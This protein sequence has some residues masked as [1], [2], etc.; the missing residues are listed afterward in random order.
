VGQQHRP[1]LGP[2]GFTLIELAV[3]LLVLALAVA[4][5]APA[6]SRSTEAIRMRAEVGRFSALLRHAR[7][8]AIT[9]RQPQVLVVDPPEHRLTIL[10]G[11]VEARETRALPSHLTITAY[12]P[13]ALSVRFEPHGVSSGGEFLV[14]SGD[15]R[16]RVVVDPLTGRVRT[17]RQ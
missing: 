17:S 1:A 5:A 7:E 2:R 3:T 9:S 8:E 10:A 4:L 14:Q 13:T 12:P 11:G 16:Y 6:V 15:F